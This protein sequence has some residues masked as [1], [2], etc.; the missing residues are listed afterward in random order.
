[1]A[2]LAYLEYNLGREEK[3]VLNENGN[4]VYCDCRKMQGK[5]KFSVKHYRRKESLSLYLIDKPRTPA[6][7]QR[8]KENIRACRK[9]MCRT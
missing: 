3:P 6:E 1:M 5:P 2:E 9:D 4:Q 8:N 7:R